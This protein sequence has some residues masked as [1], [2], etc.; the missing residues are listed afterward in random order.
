MQ[1]PLLAVHVVVAQ[2]VVV[3]LSGVAVGTIATAFT[4][5]R[6]DNLWYERQTSNCCRQQKQN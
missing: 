3:V 1:T 2:V 5:L 6:G 4:V